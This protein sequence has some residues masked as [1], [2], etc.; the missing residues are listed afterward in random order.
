M[1]VNLEGKVN[2]LQGKIKGLWP[3]QQKNLK[4]RLEKKA[5]NT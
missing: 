4:N 3:G 1:K 2:I 5:K